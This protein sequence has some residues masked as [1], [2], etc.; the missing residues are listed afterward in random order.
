MDINV[1][2][3]GVG[4][5][6]LRNTLPALQAM[7][8]VNITGILTR[9]RTVA[10]Q[11]SETYRCESFTSL[12]QILENDQVNCVYIALPTGLHAEYGLK[13]VDAGKH[14][15]C[16]KSLTHD[17]DSCTQL[18]ARAQQDNLAVCECFMYQFHPQF[19]QLKKLINESRI[20]KP[21]NILARFC[22][23]H[24]DP[25]DVRYSAALGGGALLDA[26]CYLLHSCRQLLQEEPT[27]VISSVTTETG[28]EV[29]TLGYA[30]LEFGAGE[31]AWLNWG[32]GLAY[33]NE[34]E[35]LG[36]S[37]RIRVERAFSKPADHVSTIEI[38]DAEG[39]R[40]VV[41]IPPANHFVKM[42]SEFARA[43]KDDAL[44]T[45]WINDA[46]A[47]SRLLNELMTVSQ[48]HLP[49]QL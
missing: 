44:K 11:A 10:K 13:V 24:R 34:L 33:V 49:R 7:N 46:M 35:V 14:L 41:E 1:A 47:Q 29:D 18:L 42:F 26:G 22:F 30:V 16:E 23:P 36:E 19:E 27:A 8:E 5:H 12:E 4:S 9:N 40:E 43:C 48:A 45:A 37:G 3:I 28:F 2:V 6:A 38:Q 25:G 31:T 39:T 15:W 21:R 32:Y 20:G 17:L